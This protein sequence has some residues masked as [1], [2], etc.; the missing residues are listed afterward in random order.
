MPVLVNPESELGKEL[1]K[2]DTPRNQ[3]VPHTNPPVYGMK[4][5]GYERY[6]AMLYKAFKRE[7]GK[8]MCL[9]PVPA[10]YLFQKADEYARAVNAAEAFN[11]SCMRTVHSE[12][13]ERQAANEGWRKS[14][15][16]AIDHLE[17]CEKAIADAAAEA[18]AAATRMTPKAQAERKAREA[19][20]ADHVTQ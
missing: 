12:G 13:E 17:A 6:P 18:A 11:R 10:E 19:A 4:P 1:A 20:T 3:I 8:H 16:D 7:N 14:P 2:W 5:V 15:K 9:E